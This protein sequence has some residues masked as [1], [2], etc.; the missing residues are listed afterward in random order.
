MSAAPLK[1][2]LSK[3]EKQLVQELVQ[4]P[5]L[6]SEE[7]TTELLDLVRSDEVKNIL[8]NT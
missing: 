3:T 2:L 7:K 4:L 1:I 6:L 5:A 8:E